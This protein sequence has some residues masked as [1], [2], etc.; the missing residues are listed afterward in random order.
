MENVIA[1]EIARA[2]LEKFGGDSLPEIRTN[3]QSYLHAAPTSQ[4]SNP[5]SRELA[6]ASSTARELPA[7]QRVT[8]CMTQRRTLIPLEIIEIASPCTAS[9]DAM[10][11]DNRVRFCDQCNLH[12]YNLSAMSRQEASATGFVARRPIMRADVS[13][14]RRN[15]HHRRLRPNPQ[16]G[17]CAVMATVA[18]RTWRYPASHFVHANRDASMGRADPALAY[19]Q[20]N[21]R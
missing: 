18:S 19:D 3:Y 6:R 5:C 7:A 20:P 13:A 4:A 14:S 21:P 11:G 2:F 16:G 15:G 1:F 8:P 17:K 9:W 10:H 12:V